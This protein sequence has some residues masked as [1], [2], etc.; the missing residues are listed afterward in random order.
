MTRLSSVAAF[1]VGGAI[2]LWMAIA[3]VGSNALALVVSLL[4]A[5]A[6]TVGFVELLNYQRASRGLSAALAAATAPPEDLD[7]WLEQV[8]NSLRNAV[9]QRIRGDYVG[10]PAPLLSPYLI[11]LLVMLGL[12]GTFIGMVDTL[13]GAVTALRGSNELEAVRAGL[14]APIQGLSVAFA[15]SVAGVS[16]SALLGLISILSRRERL[17]ASRQLDSRLATVFAAYS[18]SHQRREGYAAMQAQSAALPAVVERLDTLAERLETMGTTL[19]SGLQQEQQQFHQNA[20]RHYQQ[21]ATSVGESLQRSLG[22]SGRLAGESMRPVVEALLGDV[23][24]SLL[25]GQQQLQATAE[26]HLQALSERFATTSED[27]SSG[28]QQ[29]LAA[30]QQENA[31]LQE[32]M[33]ASLGEFHSELSRASGALVAELAEGA[34]QWQQRQQEAEQQRLQ[35][36]QIVSAQ[37]AELLRDSGEQMASALSEWQAQQRVADEQRVAQWEAVCA[38]SRSV[39]E[40]N[41]EQIN[42]AAQHSADE[43]LA[44][45]TDL[46]TQC[47]QLVVARAEGEQQWQQDF[48]ARTEQLNGTVTAAFAELREQEAERG[49]AAV[50]RLAELEAAVAGHLSSLATELTGPMAELMNTASE[51]PRVAAELM[52]KLREELSKNIQRDNSLI[53]ERTELMA[54]LNALSASLQESVNGQRELVENIVAQSAASLTEIAGRFTTALEGETDKLQNTVAEVAD[55]AS[56][57]ACLGESFAAAVT[58][59][60]EANTGLLDTLG[61]VEQSL[62]ASTERSD[63]QLAYY[64]AQ[65]REI[66]D[67]TLLS[68]QALIKQLGDGQIAMPLEQV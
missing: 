58:Q 67:N 22:E 62:V 47:E 9:R 27:F 52:V 15:T 46:L 36:W 44:K 5:I 38:Q 42:V 39:I 17:Q 4:I 48:N 49:A 33:V 18:L 68:Q 12:L 2:V 19:T 65:A 53:E 29:G 6:Y 28:W 40:H 64:V 66:I 61:R 20:E 7:R 56:E 57:L 34:N 21:L 60:G 54:Q 14:A 3:V 24:R 10:L 1:A 43:L 31:R 41:I 11:G 13:N 63:E 16:A 35:Q 30:Q 32:T 26:G 50:Q 8:P 55:G 51:A 25:E 37:S 23:Q 59:F 45:M